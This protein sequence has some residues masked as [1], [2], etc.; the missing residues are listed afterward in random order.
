MET[1]T[2]LDFYLRPSEV[3]AKELLNGKIIR[4][5]PDKE[6]IGTI[7]ETGAYEGG[8]ITDKRRGM[9]Y[10]G[11]T[12]FLM[13]YRGLTSLNIATDKKNLASCV[14][15]RAAEFNGEILETPYRLAKFLSLNYYDPI[16][17]IDGELLGD[18]FRIEPLEKK[19]ED[20]QIT[21]NKPVGMSDNCFAYYN[22]KK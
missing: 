3:V 20:S 12:I 11:G 18:K 10:S 13:P 6:I 17:N 8:K 2:N 19:L 1:A 22:V 16:K 5:L 9:L 14:E 7:L 4:K 21:I 15:I